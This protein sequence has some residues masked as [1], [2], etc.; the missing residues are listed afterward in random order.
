MTSP[1][2]WSYGEEEAPLLLCLHGIG[3]CADAF[4]QQKELAERLGRRIVAWDAPGYRNSPDPEGAPGI[5]GFADAAAQ[6]ITDLGYDSAD[7]VGVSWG[8][9]TATRLTLRHPGLVRT[10]TLADSSIGSGTSPERAENMRQR[11]TAVVE[12]GLEAFARSRSPMLVSG[13]ASQSLI[14]T[15][16][17]MM[18]DSVRLPSYQWAC[19]SMAEADHAARLDEIACPTLVIIGDADVIT[20]PELSDQLAAGISGAQL[21]TI[22]GAGHLSNQECPGDFNNAVA[23]FLAT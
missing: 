2:Y 7:V 13:G 14:D 6:L 15:A 16:A 22:V 3:S 17:Q 21:T 20:P 18:I 23:T 11:P 10:L 12:M 1:W 19:D 5:D 9:V 4:E 8:G